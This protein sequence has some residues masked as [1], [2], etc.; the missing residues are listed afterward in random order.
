MRARFQSTLWVKVAI[1]LSEPDPFAELACQPLQRHDVTCLFDLGIN[2]FQLRQSIMLTN[3][4]RYGQSNQT[5]PRQRS[6]PPCSTGFSIARPRS[7]SATKATDFAAV[8]MLR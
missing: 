5:L 2:C 4:K 3:N 7:S 1:A 8:G 6:S